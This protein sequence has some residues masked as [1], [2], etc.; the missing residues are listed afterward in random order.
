MINIPEVDISKIMQIPKKEIHNSFKTKKIN[1]LKY[2]IFIN[3]KHQKDYK[4]F[5][6]NKYNNKKKY[7]FN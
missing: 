2:L 3:D 4:I 5:I 6:K 7:I 1:D